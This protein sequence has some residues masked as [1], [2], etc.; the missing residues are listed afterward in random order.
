MLTQNLV[1]SLENR[2]LL[3][4]I[5]L[6]HNGILFVVGAGRVS[7]TVVVGLTPEQTAVT[8][9]LTFPWRGAPDTMTK[10]YP[11]ADHIRLLMVRGGWGNDSITIDQTNGA[12]TARALL[13]G[14]PG[15]DTIIGGDGPETLAGG[16]GN[17]SLVGGN[18]QHDVM[19]GAAGNDT[20][21]AGSAG[22]WMC[23]GP[24]HDSLV[25][26]AGNDTLVSWTGGDTLMGGSGHDLFRTIGLRYSVNNFN[27]NKDSFVRLVPPSSGGGGSSLLNDLLNGLFGF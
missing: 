22:D 5:T 2:R 13:L 20:I 27:S 21:V 7:N 24:G 14:G 25:G 18:T 16:A 19:F 26:G 1:E 4:G 9:S 23:G 12:F 8:A 3:A 15:N 6:T 10:T 11:L 17:D